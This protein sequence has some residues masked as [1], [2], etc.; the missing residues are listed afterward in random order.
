M[1]VL[2]IK[3]SDI[4]ILDTE[5][6]GISNESSIIK[7]FI[8]E[9]ISLSVKYWLLHLKKQIKDILDI[10][11]EIKVDLV[12][13]YGQIDLE[14]NYVLPYYLDE[15]ETEINP[16]YTLFQEKF[17]SLLNEE[18]ELTYMPIQFEEIQNIQTE[19]VYIFILQNLIKIK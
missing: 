13:A 8:N 6:N 9:K 11:N 14:G 2:K 7:G 18:R 3:I 1:E 15:S 16:N 19:S 12:K 10:V 5:I 4:Y 17:N